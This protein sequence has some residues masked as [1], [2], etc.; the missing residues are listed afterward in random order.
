MN[1]GIIEPSKQFSGFIKL[2]SSSCRVKVVTK[3]IHNF[4]KKYKVQIH[5]GDGTSRYVIKKSGILNSDF[6]AVLSSD[7]EFNKEVVELLLSFGFNKV[8]CYV[9][10]SEK[11]EEELKERGVETFSISQLL[12][13]Y[14]LKIV[15]R[16]RELFLPKENFKKLK[17]APNSLAVGEKLKNL[18]SR[19][20]HIAAIY[21]D[22]KLIIPSPGVELKAKDVVYVVAEKE[23]LEP[24]SEFLT[25]G[26]PQFPLQFGTSSLVILQDMESDLILDEVFYF[27]SKIHVHRID[28]LIKE[29]EPK[30][31]ERVKK[32][33]ANYPLLYVF[34]RVEKLNFEQI[35]NILKEE[36]FGL[37]VISKRE[38][39]FKF[40]LWFWKL[41][42]ETSFPIFIPKG[43][44]PYENI[45]LPVA[46]IARVRGEMEI[47]VDI[48]RI[49]NAKI[50]ALSVVEPRIVTGITPEEENI[51]LKDVMTFVK[52]YRI[53]A[54]EKLV[55]GNPVKI[56]LSM[57]PSFNLIVLSHNKNARFNLL[58]PDISKILIS[59]SKISTIFLPVE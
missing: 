30:K 15:E 55:E 34:H 40:P 21:R 12:Y 16:D 17:I 28:F 36:D 13:R 43:T 22:G 59:K 14:F 19:Y 54:T 11:I 10:E 49:F 56:I 24:I 29:N 27:L 45:L 26:T 2:I 57:I 32:R 18:R 9:K 1:I 25:A 20:W 52:M 53:P 47:A 6:I 3:R 38:G 23:T 51:A 46:K 4:L 50:A 39:I 41:V 44:Y 5:K 35:K 58:L 8:L 37:L 42:K 31:E 7:D 48:A 33:L